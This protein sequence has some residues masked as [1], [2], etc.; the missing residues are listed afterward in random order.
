MDLDL[1]MFVCVLEGCGCA[2][3][4]KKKMGGRAH[5]V[6]VGCELRRR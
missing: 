5:G 1:G 6:D 3:G 2:R 4:V